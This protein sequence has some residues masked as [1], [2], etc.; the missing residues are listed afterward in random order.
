VKLTSGSSSGD[1]PALTQGNTTG[2]PYKGPPPT[3]ARFVCKVRIGATATQLSAY[4]GLNYSGNTP[5][6]GSNAVHAIGFLARAAGA[7]VNWHGYTRKGTAESTVDLSV[8]CDDTWR[9]LSFRVTA[10]GVQF[11]VAGVDTGAEITANIPAATKN[12]GPSIGIVSESAAAREL[13]VDY[14]GLSVDVQRF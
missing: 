14:L 6:T 10:T 5:P 13:Y 1:G 4:V 2:S 9:E 3:G 7:G 8:A 11:M 12:L